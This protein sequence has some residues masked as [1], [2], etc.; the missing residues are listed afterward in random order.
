MYF[1]ILISD[2]AGEVSVLVR[3]FYDNCKNID[4]KMELY[5]FAYKHCL[6]EK[7]L[8][9]TM[10]KEIVNNFPLIVSEKKRV[11]FI[12]QLEETLGGINTDRYCLMKELLKIRKLKNS[13]SCVNDLKTGR[14]DRYI[15]TGIDIDVFNVRNEITDYLG[16]V[17]EELMELYRLT[18]NPSILVKGAFLIRDKRMVEKCLEIEL[19]YII[20]R[21]Y[22]K[23]Q[24]DIPELLN[25]YV[26]E[27]FAYAEEFIIYEREMAKHLANSK[28][29]MSRLYPVFQSNTEKMVKQSKK[30]FADGKVTADQI[31]EYWDNVHKYLDEM[32]EDKM[33]IGK[34][35]GGFFG[36]KKE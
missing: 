1:E 35:I 3:E 17:V 29:K 13:R 10:A 5:K 21:E 32:T 8:F 6:F 28:L 16:A 30:R 2:S 14:I 33:S 36:H 22:K 19:D 9:D 4:D 27:I 25:G 7:A 34:I 24:A 12:E 31:L 18:K 11:D 26:I 15:C 20:Q 23:R